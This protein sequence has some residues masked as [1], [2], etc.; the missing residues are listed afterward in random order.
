MAAP[1]PRAEA[2]RRQL[3]VMFCDL[4]GSTA[5]STQ[6]DPEDM[7]EVIRAYQDACAGVITR[8]EGFVAKY[9]GDGVLAYFGFPRAHE[10]DAERA[11]RAGLAL[12]EAVARLPAPEALSARIGIATGLVVVG[13]LVGEGA[14]QEQAVVGDTP[15]LAARL[16]SIAEPGQVVIAEATRR[17][18]GARFDLTAMEA[19]TLKGLAGPV[20]AFVVHGER[21]LESRFD[22]RQTEELAAMVGRD[23]EL[24]LLLERWRQAKSGEGQMVLLTG[25]AGI[26]K[27]RITQATIAAVTSE[28]HTLIRYQCSP[29]HSD[30]ALYPTIQQLGFAA[31][32]AAS[33]GL[34][35]RLD[36]LEHLVAR[37]LEQP[38]EVVPL[39]A[40]LLELDGEARYGSLDLAP[41]QRRN[42]TLQALITQLLGLAAQQTVLFVV[43]DVHW[44]D[45]TTLELIE[46]CLDQIAAGRVLIMVTARPT[47]S[48]SFGGH[49]IVTRLALNRLGREQTGA[50]VHSLTGGRDLPA[51]LMDEIAARTDG[52]PLFVEEL[53]KTVLESGVLREQDD[54]FVLDHPLDRLAIPSSLHDSLMARLDRLQPVKEVAQTA[55][56]I[57]REFDFRLLAA[58]SPLSG[59][60]LGEALDRLIA[61]ELVFRRGLPP[62]AVYTFKHA[63][64]RDAAYESLLKARRQQFHGRIVAALEAAEEDAAPEIIAQHAEAADLIEK[65][66]DHWE[67]AGQAAVARPA[68][69]EAI[70][71]LR[72]AIRLCG[73][74]GDQNAAQRR[75]LQLQVQLGQALLARLGYSAPDTMTAF[76]RGLELAEEIGEPTLLIPSIYGLWASRY[77]AHVPLAD[78]ADRLVKLTSAGEDSGARC[79]AL[80]MAALEWFHGGRYASSLELVREALAIYD[81]NV[82]RDLALRFANDPRMSAMN[83]K[84]WNLWHLGFP[85]QARSAAEEALNWAREI[86]HPNTTGLALCYGTSL[87]NIWL[88]DIDRVEAAARESLQLAA[89]MSLALW[90]AWGQIHLGWALAQR[91]EPEALAEMAAGLEQARQIG[92]RRLE[93]FHL[94]LIAEV[95]SRAGQHDAARATLATAF[96]DHHKDVPFVADL[97]RLRAHAALRASAAATDEASDDLQRALEIARKQ[98]ARSL[99]LRAARDLARIWAEE[100]E[101]QEAH[102]LLAPIHAWFTEGF[103]TPDLTE[104]KALLEELR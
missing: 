8:F 103:D 35:T 47:F 87:P 4:V 93:G 83:Y 57:G 6:L 77:I 82:H 66:L 3:T 81:P 33:D 41:Q 31:G 54:T 60:A 67:A 22:A 19:Q 97:Y 68:Y 79:V 46:L 12:V 99:Q 39:M 9:M 29:Y 48:H 55:A 37:A 44:I 18:M 26:G 61:A 78:L 62:E 40:A 92:A 69:K 98:G 101:R 30:S 70:A 64:V 27:S 91:D 90:Q 53:T 75:E 7:R 21:A 80:R 32:F 45:P 104:A 11:V 56:C 5:L 95:Q 17:L 51:E 20:E 28:P 25:E 59:E 85:D 65:A 71:H 72:A 38:G 2:E 49:P 73:E 16:Q 74:L 102:D 63:L 94:G 43:E 84:S 96:E 14:S 13:D 88:R 23:Q 100:G 86:D 10:D 24:A 34:E 1:E 50:I 15:N 89:K 52:V 76:E 42:R 58:V 36:K